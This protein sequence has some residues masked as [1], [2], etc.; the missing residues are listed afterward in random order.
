MNCQIGGTR[1]GHTSPRKG[2]WRG[3]HYSG[4]VDPVTR[5]IRDGTSAW[6]APW[7]IRP[8]VRFAML[9][10]RGSD[11]VVEYGPLGGEEF[12]DAFFGVVEHFA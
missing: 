9:E 3:E 5:R 12:V 4:E 8:G 2:T 7:A 1:P 11:G 6:P 10:L